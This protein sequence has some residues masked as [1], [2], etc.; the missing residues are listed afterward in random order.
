MLGAF[1]E[2][3]GHFPFDDAG[4]VPIAALGELALCD[5]VQEIV[6]KKRVRSGS[7]IAW[8][9]RGRARRSTWSVSVKLSRSGSKSALAAA[10][11]MSVRIAR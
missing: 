2:K 9:M 1:E 8:P 4:V 10:A 11:A 6:E 3:G 5:L 7:F